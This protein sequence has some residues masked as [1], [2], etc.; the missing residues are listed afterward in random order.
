M[1]P[2]SHQESYLVAG[3][4]LKGLVVVTAEDTEIHVRLAK[5]AN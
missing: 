1:T 3:I 5:M 2:K 4:H